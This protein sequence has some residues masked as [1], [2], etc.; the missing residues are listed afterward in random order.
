MFIRVITAAALLALLFSCQVSE[1]TAGV[2][3]FGD[4][5]S[6]ASSEF[7]KGY[8]QDIKTCITAITQN[9]DDTL[10]ETHNDPS[11]ELTEA[12]NINWC[13]QVNAGL[14]YVWGRGAMLLDITNKES[15]G[16]YQGFAFSNLKACE[17][18]QDDSMTIGLAGITGNVRV[19]LGEYAKNAPSDRYTLEGVNTVHVQLLPDHKDVK[20]HTYDYCRLKITGYEH[21]GYHV[22]TTPDFSDGDG[23][24]VPQENAEQVNGFTTADGTMHD[25][26]TPLPEASD[27]AQ[28]N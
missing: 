12:N 22:Y 17:C 25:Q 5:S 19:G 23:N 4:S 8:Y 3:G 7:G 18:M 21:K 13:S 24:L 27:S 10:R 28:Q 6:K 26:V 9:Q 15:G 2:K 20:P 14:K 1:D 16:V 11:C